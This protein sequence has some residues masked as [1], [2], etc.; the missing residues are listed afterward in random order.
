MS[1]SPARCVLRPRRPRCGCTAPA[2]PAAPAAA[3][4][5]H[6]STG[7]A[8]DES[9]RGTSTGLLKA[10]HAAP[11]RPPA[12][13]HRTPYAGQR[14]G[15]ACPRPARGQGPRATHPHRPQHMLM[16]CALP[17]RAAPT[18][19]DNTRSSP[20]SSSY[21]QAPQPQT[22]AHGATLPRRTHPHGLHEHTE[23]SP[24][25]GRSGGASSGGGAAA[26]TAAAGAGARCPAALRV[27]T[28]EWGAGRGLSLQDLK[29]PPVA[30]RA[31]GACRRGRSDD[32]SG[33]AYR[34][35][36]AL[37]SQSS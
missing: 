3:V 32:E 35:A 27:T 34:T 9:A 5:A 31:A 10:P 22:H 37:L 28:R 16:T 17:S 4:P 8:R 6:S 23:V 30:G 1:H 21:V 18:G 14:C 36:C 25:G 33:L 7:T 24:H 13:P 19:S 15:A 20:H 26:G 2:A 11:A 29:G 12:H